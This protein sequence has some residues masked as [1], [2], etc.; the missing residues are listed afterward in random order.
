[1]TRARAVCPLAA[2]LLA[3]FG[4]GACRVRLD[5]GTPD[6]ASTSTGCAT[7]QDC[8][9]TTLHCDHLSGK[10]VAC[11]R[12]TDCTSPSR[13]ICDNELRICVE[14]SANQ[15]C[16]GGASGWTCVPTTKSCLRSCASAADCA[17]GSWCDDG[18]CVHCDDD[19]GCAGKLCDPASHQCTICVSNAQCPVGDMCDRTSGQ[20]VGCLSTADC[21]MGV[22]DPADWACKTPPP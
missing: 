7:D 11:A 13:M 20:C 19:H 14:C 18:L 9:L 6:A 15:D 3:A 10:C 1:M 4:V 17:S 22:C 8:P 5:F 12:D 2:F 21:A 16:G